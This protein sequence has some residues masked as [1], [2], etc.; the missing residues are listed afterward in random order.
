MKNR[1]SGFTLVELMV[2]V[3]LVALVALV[4]TQ[5]PLFSLSSWRKGADRLRMQRDANLAMIKIQRKLR[6]ASL[7]D[8][9]ASGSTLDIGGASFSLEELEEGDRLYYQTSGEAPKELVIG[10]KDA[11]FDITSFDVTKGDGII[12][13]V[14]TLKMKRENVK[15]TLKTEV[16]PRN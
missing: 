14:L 3:V 16:K 15:T 13:I 11:P 1:A 9:N 4:A 8:I 10:G 5:I 2:V 6:P 7:S 12:T